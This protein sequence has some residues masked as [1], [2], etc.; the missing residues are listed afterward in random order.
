MFENMERDPIGSRNKD[1]S[2]IINLGCII[3]V[4][5]S[6]IRLYINPRT[7]DDLMHRDTNYPAAFVCAKKI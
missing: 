3:F 2:T 7:I 1:F 5:L 4:P 6:D